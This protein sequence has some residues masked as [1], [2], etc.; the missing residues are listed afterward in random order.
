MRCEENFPK[1]SVEAANLSTLDLP[2]SQTS[3]SET[4]LPLALPGLREFPF[5]Q[6]RGGCPLS[7]AELLPGEAKETAWP[8]S[9]F[10]TEA[11]CARLLEPQE[12]PRRA[13]PK[14]THSS[15]S[16]SANSPGISSHSLLKS[17]WNQYTH[18]MAL[19]TQQQQCA[20]GRDKSMGSQLNIYLFFLLV[21]SSTSVDSNI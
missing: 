10:P 15:P 9:T 8:H 17:K 12:E 19:P 13:A 3:C 16:T 5:P 14:P 2:S 21:S 7:P 11:P 20:K 6:Q 18:Q 1:S 4:F